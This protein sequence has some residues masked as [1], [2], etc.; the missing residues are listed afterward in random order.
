[1][2]VP[3][4][5]APC[6]AAHDIPHHCGPY[7]LIHALASVKNEAEAAV[8]GLAYTDTPRLVRIRRGMELVKFRVVDESAS[9]DIT[10][11][12]QPYLK[13]HIR[14]GQCLNFYGKIIGIGGKRTMSN[15]VYEP[16]NAPDGVTGRIVPVYRLTTGL[17]QKLV[18]HAVRQA[19]DACGGEL[20]EV[21]PEALREKYSLAQ[22]GF[23]YENIHFPAD[24]TALE[25]AR[26]R[27]IFE[28]LFLLA[29]ALGR[30]KGQHSKAAAT[31]VLPL[32]T[33]P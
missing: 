5:V 1:M 8:D 20:P 3:C 22:T 12:N 19:L 4:P 24:F 28:E 7:Y 29:C 14:R 13:D 9:V 2:L 10:Y 16:E 31:S 15:P 17:S 23:A 6:N 11:F 18:M 27:L 30:M 21:L 32:P 25:L 33:S 26:R